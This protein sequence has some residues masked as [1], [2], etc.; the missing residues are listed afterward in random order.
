MPE[1]LSDTRID[2]A[3][4]DL[5]DWRREGGALRRTIEAYDFRTAIR[6][7]DKVAVEAESLQHH[8]D[9]DIRYKTVHFALSTH[10]AG[11]IT[12]LDVDLA[13]RIETAAGTFLRAH[14]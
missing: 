1:L 9:I 4:A 8:P 3:I 14:E 7:L 12:E 11:G 2:E 6:I 10:S 5:P 13:H